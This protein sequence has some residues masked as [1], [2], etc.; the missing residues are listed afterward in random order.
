MWD[1]GALLCATDTRTTTLKA[2]YDTVRI[3]NVMLTA[4]WWVDLVLGTT[5]TWILKLQDRM[6]R[7]FEKP[8]KKQLKHVMLFSR[9][10]SV[11]ENNFKWLK[12]MRITRLHA[13]TN[14]LLEHPG[15][16]A[17]SVHVEELRIGYTVDDDDDWLYTWWWCYNHKCRHLVHEPEKN[18][19]HKT[20]QF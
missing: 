17:P 14:I 16:A 4:R 19:N 18:R 13:V 20:S 8:I 5:G 15:D 9:Q 6:A 11:I 7:G 1:S 3:P 12:L 2:H 10:C